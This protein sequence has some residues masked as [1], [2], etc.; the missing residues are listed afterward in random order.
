MFPDTN[1]HMADV[2]QSSSFNDDNTFYSR[3][4]WPIQMLIIGC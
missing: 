4:G 3:D 2:S 1:R